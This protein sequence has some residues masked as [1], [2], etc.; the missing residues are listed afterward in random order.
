MASI[1]SEKVLGFG[2]GQRFGRLVEDE[3]LRPLGE[4]LGDL[5]ELPLGDAQIA[6]PRAP[7]EPGADCREL[8]ADPGASLAPTRAPCPR[9]AVEKVLGDREVGE[10]RSV[11]IDDADAERLGGARRRFVRASCRRSRRASIGGQSAGGDCHQRGF[12]RAVLAE[13]GV[14]LACRHLERNAVERSDARKRL[15]D[16]GQAQNARA[17]IAGEPLRLFGLAVSLQLLRGEHDRDEGVWRLGRIAL[18]RHAGQRVLIDRQLVDV[19]LV[20]L[21]ALG[22]GDRLARGDPTHPGAGRQACRIRA[23]GFRA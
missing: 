5:D 16:P 7:V 8:L 17:S 20:V 13:Q 12:A 21:D 6:D 18:R 14:H 22:G 11:L 15:D 3:H 1:L 9:H 19:R 23:S 4:R 2:R 10:N